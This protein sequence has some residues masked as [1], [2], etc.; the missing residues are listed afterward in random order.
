MGSNPISRVVVCITIDAI[1]NFDD[2]VDANSNAD[3]KCVQT[4]MPQAHDSRASF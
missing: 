1:L 4:I 2:D 3:V